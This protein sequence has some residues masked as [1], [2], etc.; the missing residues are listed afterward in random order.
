MSSFLTLPTSPTQ[1]F[2]VR[3]GSGAYL[4]CHQICNEVTLLLQSHTFNLDLFVLDIE[5][6]NVVLGI[7][8]LATLGP[9]LTNYDTLTMEF[10]LQGQQIKLC[11]DDS[12]LAHPLSPAGFNKMVTSGGVSSCYMC[13]QAT[14]TTTNTLSV[15]NNTEQQPLFLVK[16]LDEFQD[17][18]AEPIGLPQPRSV[19][20]CIPLHPSTKAVNVCPYRYPHFQKNEIER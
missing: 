20:H 7:Q 12:A 11:G 16:L 15:D 3:V 2:K 10:C 9:I 18:F 19:D 5:G 8:W 6:T 13:L 4:H 1:P 14:P 17:V